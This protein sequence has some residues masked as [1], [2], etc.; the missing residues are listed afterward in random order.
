MGN[1]DDRGVMTILNTWTLGEP[2]VSIEV[3]KEFPHNSY[4]S[5]IPASSVG[6]A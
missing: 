1:K 6:R 3:N 5:S 4:L 2:I